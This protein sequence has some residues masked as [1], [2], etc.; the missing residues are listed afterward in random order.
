MRTLFLKAE[1]TPPMR[2]SIV[3]VISPS[4]ALADVDLQLQKFGLEVVLYEDYW[5]IAKKLEGNNPYEK[6][7]DVDEMWKTIGSMP[8]EE[9]QL[10]CDEECLGVNDF[11]HWKG[12]QKWYR[13]NRLGRLG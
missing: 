11:G 6:F 7:G 10:R 4:A 13:E 9:L 12:F 1:D 8:D 5:L 3:T 2:L